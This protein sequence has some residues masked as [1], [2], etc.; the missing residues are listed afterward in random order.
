MATLTP[1]PV[2]Q[3]FD[4]NGNPLVAGKLYTYAS[5][6]TTPLATYTDAGAGTPNGN[7]TIMNSRGEAAV[8]L[9]TS[10]YSF[11]LKDANDVLI[12]TADNIVGLASAAALQAFITLMSSSAGSANVG[13]IQAG[14]GAVLQT[15]QTK[16]REVITANDFGATG[17]GSTNDGADIAETIAA[18][19][20]AVFPSG[21][22]KN[23]STA[24]SL[25]FNKTLEFKSGARIS[26]SGSGS[27]SAL[28]TV[29]HWGYNPDNMTFTDWTNK[30]NKVG[31]VVDVGGHGNT[32]FSAIGSVAG[33]VG[34]VSVPSAATTGGFG[35]AGYI[36]NAS[37]NAGGAG[38]AVYG[39]ST[40][41]ATNAL[42]W[43]LNTR[44]ID[45]GHQST[46]W[47]AEIDLN[48]DNAATDVLGVECVGGSTVEPGIAKAFNVNAIG[49]F[50]SP[51]KR[52]SHGFNTNDGAAITG[53]ALGSTL[54]AA[55]APTQSMEMFR[56][57]ASNN[58]QLA[59]TMQTDIY[60]SFGFKAAIAGQ[61]FGL[62][63]VSGT[64][65]VIKI[66]NDD[67]GFFGTFPSAKPTVTGSK[68]GNAALASLLTALAGLGLITDSST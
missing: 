15:A 60:G 37:A 64:D 20:H 17:N 59:M 5:G 1:T 66:R 62:G 67:I 44:T 12:W 26:N 9:G 56:R 18:A 38:V 58:R 4:A 2:M 30:A 6:T 3:F 21:T 68:G 33:M 16:M 57:D 41:Q 19:T 14:A 28:G 23:T 42:C 25:S 45:N 29:A 8:W 61:I 36:K 39:E 22:Y 7:P 40:C 51:K 55:N 50:T 10:A 31:L 11:A 32:S 65:T 13:F 24:L 34:A 47:G 53:I 52:W 49:Y 27:L 43:G 48:I 63:T 35:V 46:V 54:E